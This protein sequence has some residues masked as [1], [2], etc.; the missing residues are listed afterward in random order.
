MHK[1]RRGPTRKARQRERRDAQ[2]LG[3]TIEDYRRRDHDQD[4][5]GYVRF[6]EWRERQHGR[7]DDG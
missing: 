5:A 2:R 7:D 3:L 1:R 6:R 4:A